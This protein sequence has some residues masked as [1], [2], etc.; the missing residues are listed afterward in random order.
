LRTTYF[1]EINA[2]A[3]RVL[4]KNFPTVGNLGDVHDIAGDWMRDFIGIDLVTGGFP[5]TDLSI[6]SKG[7]HKGL[8]GEQSGLFWEMSR[9]VWEVEPRWVIFENVPQVLNYMALIEDE[10][11]FMEFTGG[12]FEAR[13][14]GALC[15]R[16][17]AFIIG[18]SEPGSSRQVFDIAQSYRKA[19]HSGGGEAVYPM[20]LPWGGGVSLERLGSCVVEIPS[21][22]TNAT[23]IRKGD[24]VSRGMDRHRYLALGNSIVP[25]IPEQIMKAIL[26]VEAGVE[27]QPLRQLAFEF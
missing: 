17:R 2:F 16:R 24:G 26:Q 9:I 21:E 27:V 11:P 14:F 7:S 23:R 10:I 5:C 19:V 22:E 1:S 15:R 13:E 18:C 3:S 20:L 12:I 8:E 25:V 4:A 6:A